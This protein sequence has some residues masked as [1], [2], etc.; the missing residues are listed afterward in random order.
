MQK[1]EHDSS[2]FLVETPMLNSKM[3]SL[4]DQPRKQA[5]LITSKGQSNQPEWV[6]PPLEQ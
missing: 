4:D 2:Q 1:D 3:H 5:P 6:D